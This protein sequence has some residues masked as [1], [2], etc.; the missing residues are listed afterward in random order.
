MY[1][2]DKF[3][4]SKMDELDRDILSE[5]LSDNLISEPNSN[6]ISKNELNDLEI[7]KCPICYDSLKLIIIENDE[8][9]AN[10]NVTTTPCSH[11]FC[12]KCLSKHLEKNN[13]CPLCREKIFKKRN[14]KSVTVYE[15]C[16]II[17]Q[18]V[19]QHFSRNINTL[20]TTSNNLRDTNILLSA[21]KTCM[22]SALESFQ[23]LQFD[24]DS[25]DELVNDD[26]NDDT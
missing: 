26:Y 1:S 3:D 22:Y 17:N 18:T 19:N 13:K 4:E 7:G 10:S 5:V 2:P 20:I 21:I 6:L 12:Y 11:S 9:K 8:I 16:Y 15:G 14:L 23:Q 24:E 25:D